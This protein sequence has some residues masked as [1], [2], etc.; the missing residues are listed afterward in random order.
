MSSG[1]VPEDLDATKWENLEVFVNYLLER[2]LNCSGCLE[3]LISDSS[4]LAEHIS[5]AGALLY[6]GMTCETES[7]EKRGSF[8]DFM[9]NVRPK[10]SEF[11]DSLNRRIVNHPALGDLP[12]RYDLMI[13]GIRTDVE[14]F[15]KE[16]IPLGVRQTE[17]VTESQTINGA[18]IVDFDGDERT[19]PQMRCYLES[20]D[21]AE[22]EAAWSA[23]AE[24]RMQD[25]ERLSEIFDELVEIR[26][27]MALNAGFESYTHYMFRAMHRR[28][29][30][31]NYIQFPIKWYLEHTKRI[32]WFQ[33]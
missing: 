5:E 21:R 33:Y 2:E 16:N 11:S 25:N 17:L 10:L 12:A 27:Q 29:Y 9:G 32:V 22:R 4:E 15:R 30:C 3:N 24:R 14:I 19:I 31:M 6:I 7:E 18:M 20:N 13:R 1:F 26:Q 8:L 28:I 23:V